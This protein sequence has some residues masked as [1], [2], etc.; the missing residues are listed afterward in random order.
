MKHLVGINQQHA[1]P[2][3]VD[4]QVDLGAP[5]LCFLRIGI[6]AGFA[7]TNHPVVRQGEGQFH[8]PPP[9]QAHAQ[10]AQAQAQAHPP[11]PPLEPPELMV[12]E[13]GGGGLVVFDT[14]WVKPVI[15][16]TNPAAVS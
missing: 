2:I 8:R 5:G 12:R 15:F 13:G 1:S 10:P 4:A 3:L 14:P 11:P 7:W 16:P 6:Q 9:A